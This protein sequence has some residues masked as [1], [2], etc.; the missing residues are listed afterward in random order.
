[1]RG[2]TITAEETL[3]LSH[4]R[5]SDRDNAHLGL[6]ADFALC[7]PPSKVRINDPKGILNRESGLIP[8]DRIAA[9]FR[10]Y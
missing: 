2:R 3:R 5:N 7:R 9:S 10:D 8:A 1:M 4:F 6:I